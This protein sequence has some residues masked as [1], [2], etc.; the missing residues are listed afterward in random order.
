MTIQ[1]HRAEML[2]FPQKTGAP[3]RNYCHITD[4]IMVVE[5]GQIQYI[6]RA[7]EF[8]SEKHNQELDAATIIQH[9]GLLIPGMIDAHVHFPQTEI[10]ASYG[11]QLLDWL[12]TYTFPTES[13]YANLDYAQAQANQFLSLLFA[14]GTTTA[15][16]FATVHPSSV[17]AFFTAAECYNARMICGKVMMD[18]HAPPSLL[19]TAKSAYFDSKLLI[20]RWHNRGRAHYA[21]TPRFAPT[22]T[23]EQLAAAGK[24]AAE[25]PDT[26]IQTHLSENHSEI[27]WVKELFPDQIDYLSVYQHYGLVRERALFGHGVHLSTREQRALATHGAAIAFCPSSNLFLGSGLFPYQQAKAQG[28]EL[29][30]ASDVGGG[31]SLSLLKNCADA[32]KICQLQG[33]ALNA[34]E[35]LYRITQGAAIA[36]GLDQK[37]GN[38][39]PGSDADFVVLDLDAI[40]IL[41]QRIERCTTLDE[42]LFSLIT[43]G[44]ERVINKTYVAGKPVYQSQ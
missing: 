35:A 27:Q 6:G 33:Q 34:F 28:I 15:S 20:E 22:S 41:S 17:N 2:H 4:G 10:I 30:I 24:L 31:T 8:F 43:L 1:I 29:A 40:P 21:I 26:F 25:H 11:K 32:Y 19:D 36:M 3:E 9:Q 23:P 13:K 14:H 39:N 5:N 7:D 38:L 42:C 37:I 44:D 18:R 12:E 16:V